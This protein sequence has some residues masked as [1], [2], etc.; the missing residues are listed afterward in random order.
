MTTSNQSLNNPLVA[1]L[2]PCFDDSLNSTRVL[3][4]WD[5]ALMD[6]LLLVRHCNCQQI[7]M[8]NHIQNLYCGMPSMNHSWP[9]QAIYLL[10]F[11]LIITMSIGGNLVV[12]WVVLAH[13][14]MRTVTNYFLLNLAIADASI[15]LFNVCFNFVYILYY[16][17]WFG[18]PYCHF[19]NVMG[20]APTCASVFTLMSMSVDR[21]VAIMNPLRR[22]FSKQKTIT[23]ICTI[24]IAAFFCALP[25]AM[26][27][28]T[29]NF[30][31]HEGAKRTVCYADGYPDGDAKTSTQFQIYNYF[32]LFITYLLPLGVLSFTYVSMGRA[33][34]GMNTIGEH[35]QEMQ[36]RAKRKIVK[37][38]TVVGTLFM[39]CWLPYHVYFTF[40]MHIFAE[41]D[42]LV[43]QHVYMGMYWLAMSSTVVNPIVYCWMN[44]RF[45]AGFMY[46]FRWL[47]CVHMSEKDYYASGL[48]E[49]LRQAGRRSYCSRS[50]DYNG[51][52]LGLSPRRSSAKRSSNASRRREDAN[53]KFLP[54]KASP[55]R[56]A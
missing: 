14:T 17:W 51:S 18:D 4:E 19:S 7:V 40:L 12:I 29:Q 34:W 15:S 44:S 9:V 8:V 33:L 3:N 23:I 28:Y 6:E 36:I 55:N 46:A 53:E 30:F 2:G 52:L 39:V 48:Y 27:S 31:S 25:M 22:R 49:G 10:L 24:W 35:R 41:M 1:S 13:K 26:H 37:M 54:D 56:R 5:K 43:A 42:F 21:Y 11:G 38:L 45:R 16:N 50:T 47:P 20:V 32:L